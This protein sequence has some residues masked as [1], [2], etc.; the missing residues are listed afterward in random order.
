MGMNEKSWDLKHGK[1]A[2]EGQFRKKKKNRCHI[3]IRKK[4]R[5]NKKKGIIEKSKKHSKKIIGIR[6]S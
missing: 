3:I 1:E 5:I 2:T 6:C 4:K